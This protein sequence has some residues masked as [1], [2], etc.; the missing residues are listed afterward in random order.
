MDG[1]AS[2]EKVGVI[3]E[4]A[5]RNNFSPMLTAKF[6]LEIWL[7]NNSE[8]FD[9]TQVRAFSVEWANATV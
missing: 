8:R 6:I 1:V 3:V 4:I 9:K 5:K 2:S 7:K